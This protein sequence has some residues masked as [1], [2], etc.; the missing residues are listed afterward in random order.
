M[1]ALAYLFLFSGLELAFWSGEFPQ[2]LDSKSIGIVLFF[3]GLGE[4]IGGSFFGKISDNIGRSAATLCGTLLFA[5]ALVLSCYL[6]VPSLNA[7]FKL[8]RRERDSE[9]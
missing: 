7:N 6:K 5:I 8:R 4:V 3:A 9:R 1:I 2:L